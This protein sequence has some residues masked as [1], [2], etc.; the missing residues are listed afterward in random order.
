MAKVTLAD[1]GV[2]VIPFDAD[3]ENWLAT[4][5]LNKL[6]ARGWRGSFDEY[7]RLHILLD[8]DPLAQTPPIT[9]ADGYNL[10]ES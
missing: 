9:S 7:A 6:R 3:G 10:P 8:G 5:R 2:P 1:D 4:V